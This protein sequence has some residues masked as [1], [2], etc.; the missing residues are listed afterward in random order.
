MATEIGVEVKEQVFEILAF[1]T[2]ISSSSRE[3]L[4][5]NDT[6][7]SIIIGILQHMKSQ[8]KLIQFVALTLSNMSSASTA[9]LHLRRYESE[10][11]MI[12]FSDDSLAGI[13]SNLLTELSH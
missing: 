3:E 13:I 9:K 11:M 12:G 2:D 10:L 7:L 8:E 6:L 1:V 5:R 4:L